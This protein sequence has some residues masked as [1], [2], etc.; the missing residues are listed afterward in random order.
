MRLARHIGDIGLHDKV[1]EHGGLAV[2]H[3]QWH[4]GREGAVVGRHG[5][6]FVDDGLLRQPS[7]GPTAPVARAGHPPVGHAATHRIVHLGALHGNAG[8]GHGPSLCAH[9]VAALVGCLVV[10]KLHLEGGALILLYAE[11]HVGFV[12]ADGEV[13]V[14]QPLGQRE[15][16]RTLAVAVGG[17]LLLADDLVVGVAQL[18][19]QRPVGYGR[20]VDGRQ[21]FPYNGHGMN[22][23]SGAVDAA[24]GEDVGMLIGVATLI[25]AVAA[26]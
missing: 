4:V 19:G 7:Y 11:P 14:Q 10:G 5:I 6:A 8:V 26:A 12:G 9:G 18:E 13:T 21:F 1:I 25:V 15:L 23:L 22:R 16:H 3:H 24:V 20:I 2:G 17:G